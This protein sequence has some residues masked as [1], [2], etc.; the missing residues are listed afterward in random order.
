M[1]T[2]EQQTPARRR[3]ASPA[4][5][6][7]ERLTS[8]KLRD[9]IAKALPKH[10]TPD[11]ML[12]T[13]LTCLTRTPKLAQCDQHSFFAAL[14]TLSQLGLEPDGRRAHLIPYGQTCQLIVDYKGI[15]ELVMRSGLVSNLHADVVC[16]RDEF[17]FDRGQLAK[18]K[19]NFREP[20]GD[21]YAAYAL[22]RFRDG[23]EKSEVMT[24]DEVEAIRKRSKAGNNGPW[25]SDWNE[26]AK[27]TVFRRLS[28]WLPLSAEIRDAVEADDDAVID[29]TP[30]RLEIPPPA[31]A[32]T[33]EVDEIPMGEAEP[34]PVEAPTPA[35][36]PK[37]K[38]EEAAEP[39]RPEVQPNDEVEPIHRDGLTGIIAEAGSD[40]D[41]FRG[42]LKTTGRISEAQVDSIGS[43]VEVPDA[44]IADLTANKH[45]AMKKF[46]LIY[47]A[48]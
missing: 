45:A 31:F 11:R 21:V 5:T 38:H 19:I 48:K 47:G 27:K 13:T 6:I 24:R 33:D 22:C 29:V 4:P 34:A 20:R 2:T 39:D 37:R 9:E 30:K 43:M 25:V 15:V 32:R 14:M 26:M 40:F 41:T 35:K 10:L 44:V 23:S 28:K 18:H 36:P 1:T 12:R 16:D 3:E 46:I 17:E 42:W 8:P 7:K